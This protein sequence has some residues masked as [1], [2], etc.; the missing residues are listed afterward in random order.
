MRQNIPSKRARFLS[1]ALRSHPMQPLSYATDPQKRKT[2]NLIIT[3]NRRNTPFLNMKKNNRFISNIFTKKIIGVF[4]YYKTMHPCSSHCSSYLVKT[5]RKNTAQQLNDAVLLMSLTE[6]FEIFL[7]KE[8][9]VA[10]ENSSHN[11]ISMFISKY[12]YISWCP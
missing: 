12:I 4:D 8:S 5:E 9:K 2:L 11:Y 3:V 6:N 7:I 10:Q 1:R